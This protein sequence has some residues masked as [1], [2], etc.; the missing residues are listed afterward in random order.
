MG[1]PDRIIR[2][3][4]AVWRSFAPAIAFFASINTCHL[5][6]FTELAKIKPI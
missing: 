6:F 2:Q 4:R 1:L 5:K 3:R